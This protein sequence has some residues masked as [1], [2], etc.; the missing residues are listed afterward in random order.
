MKGAKYPSKNYTRWL[1]PILL[2]VGV[3]MLRLSEIG[4]QAFVPQKTITTSCRPARTTSIIQSNVVL[5]NNNNNDNKNN[6]NGEYDLIRLFERADKVEI[7]NDACLVACY[8]L[9]RFLVYDI[10]TSTKTIPGWVMQDF[11][12]LSGT[13]AS[14]TVLVIMYTI[15]GLLSRSFETSLNPYPPV[16]RSLVNV[17]LCC[18]VWLATEHALGYGPADVGGDSLIVTVVTGFLGFGSFMALAK[19]LL[20][21]ENTP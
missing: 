21:N 7:R 8:V 14:A 1:L 9:G 11:V 13:F 18:P 2:A 10:T 20:P 15:A 3:S 17:V 19:T 4:A 6:N 16:K 12:W 5:S